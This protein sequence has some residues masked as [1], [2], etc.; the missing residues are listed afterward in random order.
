MNRLRLGQVVFVAFGAVAF[1]AFADCKHGLP[2]KGAVSIK[3]CNPKTQACEP[4]R[5][6][7]GEYVEKMKEDPAL[8]TVALYASP[9]H[10]YDGGL[11]I[12]TVK[13]LA[14]LVQSVLAKKKATA[15]RVELVAS[16]TGV[17]PEQGRPSIAEAL[18]KELGGFPVTGAKGFI[19]WRPDGSVRI[20]QQAITMHMGGGYY[21]AKGD[22]VMESAT[23]AWAMEMTQDFRTKRDAK[24]LAYAGA[25]WDIYGLCPPN[26]LAA[27]EQAA[28]LGSPVG[29]Y[30]A[31]LMRLE[32]GHKDDRRRAAVL[33]KKAADMGDAKAKE[34]LQGL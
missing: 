21:V 6:A 32:S 34:R 20:T 17:S 3:G 31:A 14:A 8:L 24:D 30:N 27:F 28:E 19:W 4:A 11:R 13:E 18:S 26:A 5:K 9:W 10:L 12:Q 25:A 29:A 23:I 16:W 33:L 1:T 2:L 22:D 15:K 7:M